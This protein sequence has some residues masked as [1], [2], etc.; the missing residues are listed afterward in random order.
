M[1]VGN[2]ISE[3]ASPRSLEPLIPQL[4][5]NAVQKQIIPKKI[6]NVTERLLAFAR[7]NKTN[8]IVEIRTIECI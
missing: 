2:F 3:K 1:N 4:L 8:Q 5:P 6:L 7:P